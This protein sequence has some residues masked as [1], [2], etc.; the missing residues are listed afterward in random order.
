MGELLMET[1]LGTPP[2]EKHNK[3]MRYSPFTCI[4]LQYN[5]IE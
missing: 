1:Y 3:Y 5:R 4:A 2:E